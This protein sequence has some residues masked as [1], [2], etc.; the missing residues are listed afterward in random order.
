[1]QINLRTLAESYDEQDN[2][3]VGM[4]NNSRQI[5]EKCSYTQEI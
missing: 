4:Q 3:C 1:M 2:T 5:S